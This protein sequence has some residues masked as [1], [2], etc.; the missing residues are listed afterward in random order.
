MH[1]IPVTEEMKE[2][3]MEGQTMFKT[4]M[5][6][7]SAES[8]ALQS[9]R[10]YVSE[11][12]SSTMISVMPVNDATA[13][14]LGY[15]SADDLKDTVAEYLGKK[16]IAIFAH[17]DI[18]DSDEYDTAIYHESIHHLAK[19]YPQ[20]V[21]TG[22]YF[23]DNAEK[24]EAMS[25][26][27]AAIDSQYANLSE[28]DKYEEML[29]FAMEYFASDNKVEELAQK[30]QGEDKTNVELINSKTNYGKSRS[31][32]AISEDS[33]TGEEN[34]VS[35]K[36]TEDEGGTLAE[37]S[38]E[39][40]FKSAVTPEVRKEMDTISAQAIVNGNYLKAPNGKD[41]NL[42]P[43]QWALVRTKNFKQWFGDWE[44]EPANASKVIDENGEP[45]VVYH[46]T[47]S[48]VYINRETGENWDELDWRAR[49][50]WDERDDWDEYW[51]E[52]DFNTFSRVNARTTNELDGFFFAPVYDEYHEYGDRTIPV[53]LNIKNPASREDYNIDSSR[54]NAGRDE[55][56]RLQNEGF[57]GV[58][59]E[60][61]G[62]IW[63][64]VAFNPN[65]IK[66][67]TDNTGEYS[68][69]EDI[70]FKTR[71]KPAPIKTQ[72]VYKLMRLGADG[73]L[74]P[75]YIDSAEG[76]E[77]KVWYDADSP[78]M[79]DIENLEVGYAYKIDK[80]GNV[81]ET[82]KFN[83]TAAGNFS[84]FPSKEQI[85]EATKENARWI[86][87]TNYAEKG[88][89]KGAK[90]YYNLGINGSGDVSIFGMRPGW[91]AGSLPTMRQIGKA[92]EEDKARA[93]AE[94]RKLTK[95]EK[96][97]RDDSFVWVRGYIPAD[98]DYQAEA[99]ANPEHDIQTH[100]PTDGYYLKAT[101][102]DKVASQADK[103]GWYIAGAFYADEIIS[104]AEARSVIDEWNK[105]HPDAKVEY[106]F[107]RE[108]GREFD[109]ARGGLVESD[110]MFKTDPSTMN[111]DEL[112]EQGK[113]KVIAA[114]DVFMDRIRAINGNLQQLRMA[115]AAQ[116]QYDKRTVDA[117]VKQAN[118]LLE[119]G[120]LA[121]LTRGEIKRIL[122][123]VNNATGKV[124]LTNEVGR[125]MDIMIANQLRMGR[126]NIDKFLRI[127]GKKVDQRGVEVRGRL[128]IK[129]QQIMDTIRENIGN[130]LL[131]IL[132]RMVD[133]QEKLTSE[134][135]VVRRNAENELIGL[136][137][138][139]QYVENIKDSEKE[140]KRIRQEIKDA[141]QEYK[142][143][144]RDRKTFVD[145][146]NAANEAIRENRIQ[147]V[148]AYQKLAEDFAKLVTGSITNAGLLRDAE[149]DRVQKIQHFANSDLKGLPYNEHGKV[150]S[151]W[152]NNPFVRFLLKPLAT[153]DQML[154][155]FGSKSVNGEGYLWNHFMRGWLR[156]TETEYKGVQAAH[157][158]LDAKAREVFRREG[159]KRWSDIFEI[160]RKLP[161]AT[162]TW[163]DG[164][165]M[166]DHEV[167]QGSLLYIYMVNKMTDGKMKL[168]KMGITED[169]VDSIKNALDSRFIALADWIQ[170]E[171]LPSLRDKYNA[172]HE[173]LFGASMAAID[174]YFPIRVL[175]N[176]REREV[177]LGVEE[178]TARPS[179][180][181]GSI[182]KRTR[183]SLALDILGS[184]AFDVVLDHIQQ[185]EHWAAFAE[186]NQDLNT[187][188]SYRRF[189]N[190]VQNMSGIY[191]SG[192][193]VWSNFRSVA[194]LAAGVYQPASK[195][196][197]IDKTAIN[198]AK[199][200]TSAKISFRVYTAIKQL[201]SMPA[202]V[203]DAR[204]D[205]LLKNILS[206]WNAWKWSMEN[207]PLFEKRWKS[208]QV[209]DSRLMQT[210]SDWKIWK[211]KVVELASRYGMSP[212]AFVDAVTV[213]IGARSIYE[214]KMRIYEN[215]GYSEE[216]ASERA[217]QDATIL[218]NESQQSNE[219]AFLSTM[220]VDRTAASVA[221]S[222]FRNSA[223]GYQRMFV[224]AVRNIA[225][226]FSKDYKEESIEFMKKQLIRDGL[227]E[228]A[229]ETAANRMYT[230]SIMHSAM[231]AVTFGFV[232]QFA[233]N[234]GAYLPYLIA[235][236][237]DDEK[238][239]M[240]KDAA[241]HA[242]FGPIEGLSGGS[243]LSEMGNLI[244]SGEGL[245]DY[246]PTLLPV[247]SDM[248]RLLNMFSYDEI[249]AANEMFNLL[250]QA[251]IGVNPQTLTDSAV[252][253]IDACNGDL[254]TAKE[255]TLCLLRI[256]Q[257]PQTQ[258]DKIYIDEID[259][260]TDK[261]LELTIYEFAKRYA[262]YK[263]KRGAP[264][265]G[266]MYSSEKE[267]ER[268][269]KYIKR[270]D[271]MAEEYKRSRGSEEAK[272]YYEYLD[273]E[274]KE[275]TETIADLKSK[276]QAEG[277]KGNMVGAMEYAEMLDEFMKTDVFQRYTQYGGMAKA[278]EKLRDQ[279]LKVD[280]PT[281]E[282]LED[283]MLEIRKEMVEEMEK[284]ND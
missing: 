50:E 88:P 233:W 106:D 204:T 33:R 67:A 216:E 76:I 240:V 79:G 93:K 35:D 283:T 201:L 199:G 153:F 220:Q 48:V 28:E 19:R 262:D 172:L 111:V 188:L 42:T 133:V 10:D 60:E 253:I 148:L 12:G 235:G 14:G 11:Y 129:G 71:T 155:H 269:D 156:A 77:L 189:R 103:M 32:E 36:E 198:L 114:I 46:Q 142:D 200:V 109:P 274:Y 39:T 284:A 256:L 123:V 62:E 231:R 141:E 267:Q 3:V 261:G 125:L 225:H 83:K 15:D 250:I 101:N 166:R 49:Q 180:I 195:S 139:R 150:D 135:E 110:T 1:S 147:R 275:V 260:T 239:D 209:G 259:F 149:K 158:V 282:M 94:G 122:S 227:E 69:D 243:V 177:D 84:A 45:K 72:P 191:G 131:D 162:V 208:R 82:K 13:K 176:A 98:V 57:D 6:N 187:L 271:K 244:A 215:M 266:W 222:L 281:M 245:K 63:E 229:A 181:T 40:L 154:R 75:L 221:F 43:E 121:D 211:T 140:E 61:G 104:D 26:I 78:N 74:Y 128:D 157:E 241:R 55:R 86:A 190:R 219:S 236:D 100:I 246:D 224:D 132:M 85:N 164:G 183:N 124:D 165:E 273:T 97:Y 178:S 270:F 7:Q 53:F 80:D 113:Q 251:G 118:E 22:K 64:Y 217:K 59:R 223:M 134:S 47:N 73:R 175:A 70:R 151:M 44:N 179:T 171:F 169:D 242:L 95:K 170:D 205:I 210:D 186:F 96:A 5:P 276:A 161:T 18:T 92:R 146:A 52:Q 279:L 112:V 277:M 230:R 25:A 127:R 58:I 234:L 136:E 238:R 212:N 202:F 174:S 65:Q 90:A 185:M 255:A 117:I 51:E 167:T 232:V 237:D 264:L 29:C 68:E 89:K 206:P 2:S 207:L 16:G 143:G 280:N 9:M 144:V 20:I 87:V 173:K 152:W 268:V 272:K 214:S 108:S 120:K 278:V 263:V 119:A 66:S 213:A 105:E 249:A 159:I 81:V 192:N 160:D 30:M 218:F 41:T 193:V 196:D 102:A 23:W 138:A 54:N 37:E 21:N 17:E 91:H 107:P 116:R 254:E 126:E 99:D 145:F 252:A 27:K 38:G 168:R 34:G 194:E 265:T 182:I 24:D 137:F 130:D 31:S 226:K 248:K 4:R 257:I 115:A 258:A 197:S 184:N 8:F 56:V 203:S 163:W 247:V 228:T